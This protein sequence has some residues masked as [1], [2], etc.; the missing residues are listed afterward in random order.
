MKGNI[1]K[2]DK[3]LWIIY[4]SLIII[5]FLEVFSASSTLA[6]QAK[7]GF[8]R[9]I[10][11]HTIII[12]ASLACVFVISRLKKTFFRSILLALYPLALF[13]VILTLF[14][15]SSVN[16][17]TR[18]ISLGPISIQPSEVF[19]L[20]LVITGATLLGG[21]IKTGSG[22][23]NFI[24]YWIACFIPIAV[25]T[26]ENLS[27]GIF[28]TLFV[29]IFSWIARAPRKPFL[30]LIGV[31]AGLGFL[32]T[33][34]LLSLSSEQLAALHHRAPTWKSRVETMLGLE[35][36]HVKLTPEQ[37]DSVKFAIDNDNFQ[38]Q[39]AKIAIA[40]SK[41]VGVGPGQ[42]LERDIL[43]Q[44]YSDFIYAIIIEETGIFGMLLVPALYFWLLFRSSQ[45]ATR[46]ENKY[47]KYILW[48]FGLMYPLQ[49]M[50]NFSV[51]ANLFLTGQTLPLISRGGTSFL[52]TSI[53]FGI[54]IGVSRIIDDER[55]AKELN[56]VKDNQYVE[57]SNN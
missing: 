40:N 48:G 17:A 38:A 47:F 25:I 11:G 41:V 5:S 22:G 3:V 45:I 32:G 15:G 26:M 43:P 28:L 14:K 56:I 1:L 23:R 55:E 31:F 39:H 13:L 57:E 35:N 42:S 44:A 29:L 18:W 30:K 37:K 16:S 36:K 4:I 7:G 34:L 52:M 46:T 27:T 12:I 9:P 20:A 54:M 33:V 49:A 51:V 8:M 6:Y 21:R 10:M 24:T 53:A 2:G 19:K 50:V